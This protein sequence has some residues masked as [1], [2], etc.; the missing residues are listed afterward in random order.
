MRYGKLIKG[1]VELAPNPLKIEG[2]HIFTNNP[3]IFEQQGYLPIEMTPAPECPEGYQLSYKWTLE[4]QRIVRI[5]EI[6]EIPPE[7]NEQ[8]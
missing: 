6:E 2:R 7:E 3:E 5:W 4:N 8:L 1:R